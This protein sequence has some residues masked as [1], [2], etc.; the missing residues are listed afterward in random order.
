MSKMADFSVNEMQQMQKELQEKYKGKWE[1]IGAEIGKNKLLWMIG[2]IG[3]VIDIGKKASTD[4]RLRKDLIEEMA[5]VLMYYNDVMLC[6][7][8]TT[9]ELR[10]AYIDKFERNMT[11]W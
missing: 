3:E 1:P 10:Q 9:D 8:I 4:E 5:D 11:R 6:Y 7:G 2:E